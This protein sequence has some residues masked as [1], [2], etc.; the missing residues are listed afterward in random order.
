MEQNTLEVRDLRVSFFTLRGEV[1]AVNDVTFAVPEGKIVGI[2]GES[3]C[4]KSVTAK[5]AMGL[6][7]APGRIVGG[8]IFRR[9]AAGGKSQAQGQGQQDDEQD[10][11]FFHFSLLLSDL[12]SA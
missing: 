10:I 5:A 3:G 8:G 11:Q 12:V 6:L 1:K 4:G 7:R 2:V 9:R